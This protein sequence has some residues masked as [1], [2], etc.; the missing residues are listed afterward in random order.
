MTQKGLGIVVAGFVV[1]QACWLLSRP[2]HGNFYWAWAPFHETA[3]YTVE[4]QQGD[5]RWTGEEA[6]RRYHLKTWFKN[7]DGWYWQSNAMWWVFRAI[8]LTE[9]RLASPEPVQ[10]Q[11]HYHLNGALE[12]R[13][14]TQVFVNGSSDGP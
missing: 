10:I 7:A 4:V 11:V 6:M 13:T 14:W 9:Q 2:W 5:I 12:E 8:A 3:W 1:F